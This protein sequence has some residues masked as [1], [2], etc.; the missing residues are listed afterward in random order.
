MAV[1]W[2]I[3]DERALA[4]SINSIYC[5]LPILYMSLSICLYKFICTNNIYIYI[6][7]YIYMEV[8]NGNK[9]DC[10]KKIEKQSNPKIMNL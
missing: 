3:S 2:Q 8:N 4:I 6:Y 7:I 9:S 1:A 10:I 5:N